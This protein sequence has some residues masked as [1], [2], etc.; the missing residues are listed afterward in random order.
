MPFSGFDANA[1]VPAPI[2]A[3]N[4]LEMAAQG[5]SLK[6]A[7]LGNQIRQTEFNSRKATG[8]AYAHNYNALTGQYN[9][10]GVQAEMGSTEAGQYGLPEAV[11]TIRSQQGQQTSN[12][13][14]QLGLATASRNAIGSVLSFVGSNPDSAHL[15]AGSRMAKAVL[16]KSQ[17]GQVDAIVQQISQN[18]DGIQGGVKQLVNSMQSAPDQQGNT[19]GT[20]G[21]TLDN[22]Q[23]VIVGNQGSAINGGHFQPTTTVQKQVSPEFNYTP[24]TITGPDGTPRIVPRG[25][26]VGSEKPTVPPEVMGSGRYP[27]TQTPSGGDSS[28]PQQG[29]YVVG[30]PAGQV[31]A[32]QATA[33]ASAKSANALMDAAAQ[34]NDRLAML[35]NMESDLSGF[36]SGPGYERIRKIASLINNISPF[37]ID[38]SGIESAQGFNKWAQQLANAQAQALG[39]SDA[40]LSAAEHGNPNSGLQEGTNRLMIHQLMGNEDAIN[41]KTQAWQKSGLPASQFLQWNQKFNQNF[42]KRAFQLLRMTPAEQQDA[43]KAMKKT[44]QLETFKKT[45]NAMAAAGLVPSGR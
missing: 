45:Y 43:F 12:D 8:A 27:N 13:A 7:L 2:Q 5:I 35:Q 30:P 28:G 22:G 26:V 21:A 19:Y 14:A 20:A 6:N 33:E 32:Q 38:E 16:P 17:W 41:A 1:L 40:R 23:Q 29:G 44:G 42:D 25:Q 31:Q 36:N 18:P 39:A 3:A 4:P 9:M 34:R 15:D 10:P 24:V 11:T 37:Q